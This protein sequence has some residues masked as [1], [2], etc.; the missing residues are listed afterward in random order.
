MKKRTRSE[1]LK[2]FESLRRHGLLARAAYMCC[3]T[4][5][6]SGLATALEKAPPSRR[7][8]VYWHRQAEADLQERGFVY[9]GYAA[10]Q[11][12]PEAQRRIGELIVEELRRWRFEIVWDGSPATKILV[13]DVLAA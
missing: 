1:L 13:K 6:T 2:V 11:D 7:G 5:A 12:D 10:R 4:C 9:L 8:F 3:T